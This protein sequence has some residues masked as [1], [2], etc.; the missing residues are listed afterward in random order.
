MKDIGPGAVVEGCEGDGV[1]G[2]VG[3]LGVGDN[4]G[5]GVIPN[6]LVFW[7]EEVVFG[8]YLSAT[9]L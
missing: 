5:Y 6:G 2:S 1:V 3:G 8:R 7:F 4:G 9:F